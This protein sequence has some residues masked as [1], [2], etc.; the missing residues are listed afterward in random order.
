MPR[1]TKLPPIDELATEVFGLVE[2]DQGRGFVAQ[3]AGRQ[4]DSHE[5]FFDR[6]RAWEFHSRKAA[7]KLRRFL[8][9]YGQTPR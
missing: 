7:N 9:K 4:H 1:S 3:S 5:Q 8:R 2:L 6:V